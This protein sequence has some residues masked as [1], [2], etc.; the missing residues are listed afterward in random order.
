MIYPEITP[1]NKER[2][3]KILRAGYDADDTCFFLSEPSVAAINAEYG[4][5][6]QP[7]EIDNPLYVRVFLK[8]LGVNEEEIFSFRQKLYYQPNQPDV[9]LNSPVI[10]GMVE[11]VKEIH[12]LGHQDFVITTRPPGFEMVTEEQFKAVGIDWIK[13]DWAEGGNI[14]IRDQHY[15]E[16]MSG[17]EF[18]LR[19]V[20]GDFPDGKYK[21]FPGLDVLLE[22][23]GE[24][25]DHPL[26]AEVRER[27]FILF[28]Q[29]NRGIPLENLVADWRVFFNVIQSLSRGEDASWPMSHNVDNPLGSR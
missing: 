6:F 1:E 28:Y 16:T 19:A 5:N 4:S 7:K 26:A 12:R 23:M 18:K 2:P 13:G 29:Y 10:P 24:L 3:I 11:V 9:Y 27:I 8:R 17:V 20:R 21:D 22:N 15:M 25:L 14:L